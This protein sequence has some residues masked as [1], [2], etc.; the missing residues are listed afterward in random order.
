MYTQ[1]LH[2]IVPRAIDIQYILYTD[3]YTRYEVGVSASTNA[4]AG[5]QLK[6]VVYSREG[7]TREMYHIK[8]CNAVYFNPQHQRALHQT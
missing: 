1:A 7:G 2:T 6:V 5:E 3:P 8:L 4:G